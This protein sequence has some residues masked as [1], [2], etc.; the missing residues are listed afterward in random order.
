VTSAYTYSYNRTNSVTFLGDSMRNALRDVI[1]EHGLDPHQLMV[2]WDQWIKFGVAA[3][4]ESGHLRTIHIEFY[5]PGASSIMARWDFPMSYDGSGVD[6]DMWLDKTYLR[7]LIAKSRKPAPNCLY[8][9]LLS[10]APGAPDVGLVSTSFL[11]TGALSTRHGG[12]IVATPHITAGA[13][14]WI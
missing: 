8:R 7:Q 9:I 1:R 11:D 14:Y 5:L 12:T 6:E 3:W 4:L 13:S 10:H 2:E